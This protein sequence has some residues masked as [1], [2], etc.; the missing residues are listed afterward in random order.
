MRRFVPAAL[1]L[2]FL[3]AAISVQAPAVAQGAPKIAVISQY[4]LNRYGFA[5]INESVRITNNGSSSVEVPSLTFG[6]GNLSSM[7]AGSNITGSGFSLSSSATGGPF[8]VSSSQPL[9]AGGNTSFVLSALLNGVTSYVKNGTFRVL[10]LTTPS[11]SQRVDKLVNVIAMPASTALASSPAGMTLHSNGTSNTYSSTVPN[12]APQSAVA[13][14]GKITQSSNQDFNPLR[15]YYAARTISAG[16]NGDP[17]V[18]DKVEFQNIGTTALSLLYVSVLAPSTTSVTVLTGTEPRLVNPITLALSS[19]AID[20]ALFA[21]GYPNNG[22]QGGANFT[23]TYQYPLGGKYYSVSGGQVTINIPESPPIKA[24]VDSYTVSMS[25]PKGAAATQ[26]STV[27]L[28]P[29][30]WQSGETKFAYGLSVGFTI[31]AGVPAASLVF[32]LLLIG[33]FV[34]RTATAEGEEEEEEEETSTELAS[35]MIKVFDEKTNLINGLWPEIEAKDPNEM[36]KEYFDELRGR[37]DA[38]RSRALQRLNEVKQKSASLKFSEVVNQIQTTEREVDRAAKDKLNLYQQY[39]L[40]Q[41]RKEVFDRLLPQYNRRL[42]R[43]LNQLTDELHTVQR[44]A[45]LL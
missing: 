16:S 17:L 15:V 2:L 42:E 37:L 28:T 10:M 1:L 41:M 11:I 21:S 6:F 23:L 38:F 14:V 7:V 45:K 27:T 31:D 3:L 30:P 19:G 4:T 26:S 24:F 8:T 39:H 43:A 40:K 12:A 25:L 35:T 36:D 33:L 5:T 13:S 20:M 44:E 34:A 32:I 9:Q 22:V 29:T 18:T